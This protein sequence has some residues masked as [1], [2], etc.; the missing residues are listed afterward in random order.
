[1]YTLLFFRK[2]IEDVIDMAE[3]ELIVPHVSKE[4]DLKEVNAALQYLQDSKCTGKVVL[5][6]DD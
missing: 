1:V 4:F 2:T 3:Q 6:I 5:E